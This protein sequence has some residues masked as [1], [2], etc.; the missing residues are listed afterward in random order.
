MNAAQKFLAFI[1]RHLVMAWTICSLSILVPLGFMFLPD[2]GLRWGLIKELTQLGMANVSVGDTDLTLFDGRVVVRG[3]SAQPSLGSALGLGG[4]DLLFN[5]H[6][7]L[8]KRVSVSKADLD[9]LNLSVRNSHGRIEINGITLPESAPDQP[10][11]KHPWTFDVGELHFTKGH[12]T[13]QDDV[14]TLDFAITA[15]DVSDLRSWQPDQPTHFHLSGT[16]DGHPIELN[17]SA[18]PFASSPAVTLTLDAQA[19]ALAPFAPLLKDLGIDVLSGGMTL[20]M[21]IRADLEQKPHFGAEGKITIDNGKLGLGK[22]QGQ[23]TELTWNGTIDWSDNAKISGH[24]TAQD[25]TI[26]DRLHLGNAALDL[27]HITLDLATLDLAGTGA[28]SMQSVDWIDPN[29]MIT[30]GGLTLSL[31]NS[32]WH[33]KAQQL[34]TQLTADFDRLA[35]KAGVNALTVDRANLNCE[36]IHFDLPHTQL[37]WKGGLSAETPVFTGQGIKAEPRKLSWAGSVSGDLGKSIHVDGHLQDAG[38]K[39]GLTG[40][41]YAHNRQSLDGVADIALDSPSLKANGKFKLNTDALTIGNDS[42]HQTLAAVRTLDVNAIRLSDTGAITIDRIQASDVRALKDEGRNAYPWRMEIGAVQISQLGINATGAS[43]VG[44]VSLD[45]ALFRVTRTKD[46]LTGLERGSSST[47]KDNPHFSLGRT[48]IGGNSRVEFEDRSLAEPMRMTLAKLALTVSDL[49]SDKP[50]RDSPFDLKTKI[51]AAT[52]SAQGTIR[53]FADLPTATVTGTVKA[54]ELPPLSPY[55]S[56]ALGIQLQTG[57]LDSDAH[58]D[59]DKGALNG[60]I[61]L[62]LSNLAVTEP[63]GAAQ[64]AKQTGMPLQTVL[65]LLKDDQDRIHLSVPIGGNISDPS[66]DVSDAVSQAIGGALKST[67]MTTLEVLFPVAGLIDLLSDGGSGGMAID[68]I[69]F[70]PGSDTLDGA[71][72]GRITTIGDLLHSRPQV[73]LTLCGIATI[74]ADWPVLLED[75]KIEQLGLIYRLQKAL[76]LH[77]KPETVEPDRDALESL[78]Q[79]RAEAVKSALMEKSGIDAGRLF[80]CHP[81]VEAD[82]KAAPAV[83]LSL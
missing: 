53:P 36:Q 23:W 57:H 47:S 1:R 39:V 2:M 7:L 17:G 9:G 25:L 26:P 67:A 46:G 11:A 33:N 62:T 76:D 73:N 22:T 75:R 32:Q 70:S 6:P 31:T 10:P 42:G 19:L 79:R 51:D 13:Y 59:V 5:W 14:L 38:A 60:K 29:A 52:L 58:L 64:L 50:T 74:A 68:P 56:D 81:Q 65:G 24:L 16:L 55:A 20:H 83:R 15:L 28:L 45:N 12:I 43:S 61:Q 18:T 3:I 66:Y 37:D 30:L 48:T 35:L 8:D 27:S 41:K 72:S 69:A 4:L 71:Q 82:P 78:A 49:D 63:K 40:Y 77:A 80:N 34:D 21:A 54:F 44:T